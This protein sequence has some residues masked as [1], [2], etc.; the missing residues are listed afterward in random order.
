MWSVDTSNFLFPTFVSS[1]YIFRA[2]INIFNDTKMFS[3]RNSWE[4]LGDAY[5]KLG[6]FNAALK[7]YAKTVELDS[8]SVYALLQMARSK[9][10]QELYDEAVVEFRQVLNMEPDLLIARTYHADSCLAL[11]KSRLSQN[12]YGLARDSF[13]EAVDSLT[14]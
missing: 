5:L 12:L 8:N 6:S 7:S 10:M 9:H 4:S 3:F 2:H 1:I 13:Q 11:M 14:T